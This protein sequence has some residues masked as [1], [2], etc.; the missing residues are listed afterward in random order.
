MVARRWT[1]T[2]WEQALEGTRMTAD[3]FLA[4]GETERKFE[5]VHGVVMM[6]PSPNR[7]HQRTL[8]ELVGQVQPF[9]SRHE[10]GEVL[11]DYDVRVSDSVV[12]EPDMLFVCAEKLRQFSDKMDFAPDIV[13]EILSPS[14]HRKDLETKLRDYEQFGVPEYWVLNPEVGEAMFLRLIGSTYVEVTTADQGRTDDSYQ[15][16]LLPGFTLDLKRLRKAMGW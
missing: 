16:D 13:V 4:I 14:T 8:S 12:Y 2:N 15:T 1:T 5:L 6:S 10:L 11:T 9:V 3:E 7:T